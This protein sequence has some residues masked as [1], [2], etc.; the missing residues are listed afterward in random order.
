MLSTVGYVI[1]FYLTGAVIFSVITFGSFLTVSVNTLGAA[2]TFSV[3][4]RG[5]NSISSVGPS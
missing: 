2:V 5:A 3:I 1:I 4:T